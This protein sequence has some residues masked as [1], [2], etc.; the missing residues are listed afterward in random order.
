MLFRSRVS[1]GGQVRITA[2]SQLHAI[3]TTKEIGNGQIDIGLLHAENMFFTIASCD[4]TIQLNDMPQESSEDPVD[5][6]GGDI[7][8]IHDEEGEGE[9]DEE[10]E[11]EMD[12]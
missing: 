9:G 6:D 2:S 8:W 1:D 12:D 11:E 4:G 10:E 3:L 7:P 5:D